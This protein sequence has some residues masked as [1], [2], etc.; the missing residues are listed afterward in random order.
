MQAFGEIREG[1]IKKRADVF[2][3]TPARIGY[4]FNKPIFKFS[5]K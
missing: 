1:V 5:L 4:R 2:H 3:K